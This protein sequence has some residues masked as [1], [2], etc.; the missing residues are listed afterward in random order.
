MENRQVFPTLFVSK[1]VKK[2]KNLSESGKKVENRQSPP[3]DFGVL[4][5]KGV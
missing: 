5:R 1:M 4:T 2:W 3:N